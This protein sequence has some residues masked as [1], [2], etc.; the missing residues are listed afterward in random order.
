MIVDLHAYL[1]NWLPYRLAVNDAAGLIRLMDRHGIECA[2]VSNSEG[3]FAFDPASANQDL[4][5][6]VTNYRARLFPVGAINLALANWRA[7][8]LDGI[9]RL[10]LAGIR[11]HPTYHGY[12]LDSDQVIALAELLAERGV[13]LFL[14][15]F[16]DEERFQHPAMRAPA[17]SIANLIQLIRRVPRTTIV[18]NNLFP[19]E[20]ELLLLESDLSIENVVM[21]ITAMDKPFNGLQR[22]LTRFGNAHLVYGSQMPFL[23]PEATL[24]LVRANGF[25]AADVNAILENNWRKNPTLARLIER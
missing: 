19:E 2:F 25:P 16:V 1:G 8:A 20:A 10:R 4:A 13:P 3:M 6:W 23:Y 7:D 18:L 11:L 12:A 22:I 9:A 21:D 14:A 17:I 24:A 15:T 5:H